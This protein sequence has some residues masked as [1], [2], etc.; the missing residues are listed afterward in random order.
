MKASLLMRTRII[1]QKN[2]FAEVVLWDVP[3]PVSGSRHS[4][5]YRL[6]FVLD[7]DCVLRYDNESGKGDH[8]H[9]F[10]VESPYEFHSPERLIADFQTDIAKVLP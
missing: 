6:A 7:G 10:G 1:Y 9:L 2:A 4:F 5:K 3:V 8:R